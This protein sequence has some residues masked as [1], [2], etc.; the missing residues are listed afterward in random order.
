MSALTRVLIPPSQR[1]PVE[2]LSESL[3]LDVGDVIRKR[4]AF[5]IMLTLSGVIA[6]AGVVSDSTAT[7]IGAMI[8]AP[9]A[10]PILGIALGI[11]TGHLSL[12]LRSIGWVLVG[13]VI[14][15]ALGIL[16]T[17]ILAPTVGVENNS[18]ITGR[19]SPR[20]VELGAAVA[21]GFAGAFAICRRDLS[22][23]LPGVAI[24]ISLVPPLAV[25]GVTAGAGELPSAFGALLLFLSNVLALVV[26]GSVVLTLAGYAR[27]PSSL[28]TA[29]R[30]RAYVIVGVLSALV[31]LPLAAN[32]AYAVLLERWTDQIHNHTE[33][34]LDDTA[35]S[36]V[37]TISWKGLHATVDVTTPDGTLPSTVSL[38]KAMDGLP[39]AVSV[40]IRVAPATVRSVT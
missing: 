1:Q 2:D 28:P 7:V 25:V 24:A 14:V 20:L 31:V 33:S 21:T 4:G 37:G 3:D 12:V 17:L 10:T 13:L 19:T 15:V 39:D 30:K 29:R 16:T 22:A 5:L 32:T 8:I 9:L 40:D 23:V 38:E 26:T 6:T 34:W 27:E 11:V 35:G 36:A 18:Q